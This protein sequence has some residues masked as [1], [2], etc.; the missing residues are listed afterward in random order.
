M[1]EVQQAAVD[2]QGH[3]YYL[4]QPSI[5][6][7]CY[8]MRDLDVRQ[9]SFFGGYL[10]EVVIEWLI[11][12]VV[13]VLCFLINIPNLPILITFVVAAVIMIIRRMILLDRRSKIAYERSKSVST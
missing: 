2:I 12:F 10:E 6:L 9:E 3:Y 7:R 13:L 4:Q 11:I 8:M 5:C 1:S